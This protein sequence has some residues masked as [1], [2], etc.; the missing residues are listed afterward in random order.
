M[1]Y[2]Q[3]FSHYES[4]LDEVGEEP[5]SLAYTFR[6]LKK[7]TL[8]D[9]VLLLTK[10]VTK[11]DENLLEL[12]FQQLAHHYPAQYII[13]KADFH[14]LELMV[15]P[16]VLI[17]RPETEELVDLI[18]AENPTENL[19]VLDIGTGSGAIAISLVKAQ[20]NWK[21]TATDISLDALA[22]AQENAHKQQVQ[23]SFI[24][25]D[26]WENI[27]GPF[28]MIVSNPPYIAREDVEE[29]GLNVL[30]SEPHIALFADE[31]GLVIYRQIAKRAAE[32][33]TEKGKVYLE[34]GYKQ[35]Q[36]VKDIFQTAFPEKRVRV[37][38][39][40]FGQDR[41]VVVDDG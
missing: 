10:E 12:I 28:D 33:L 13:G 31:D 30:H 24:K 35:G 9:F 17:P 2:A 20:P 22:V 38:K 15:D 26:V 1:N 41:M 29:V 3:L 21:V 16:R 36:Q 5:E 8:T 19:S 40:Q 6:A 37:L 11:D 32:F 14:G 18:L 25:S 4:K 39:D 27:D 7:L 23:L 34:T